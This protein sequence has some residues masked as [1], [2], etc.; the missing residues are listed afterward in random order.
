VLF[1][2]FAALEIENAKGEKG[3]CHR[4]EENVAHERFLIKTYSTETWLRKK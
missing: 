2:P 1:E 4:N 3:E